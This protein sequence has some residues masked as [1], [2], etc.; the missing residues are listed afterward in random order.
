MQNTKCVHRSS[1]NS[2]PLAQKKEAKHSAFCGSAGARHWLRSMLRAFGILTDILFAQQNE[3]GS[4][5]WFDCCQRH[6]LPLLLHITDTCHKYVTEEMS[7]SLRVAGGS[8]ERRGDEDGIYSITI[9]LVLSPHTSRAHQSSNCR[10]S[11]IFSTFHDFIH[12]KLNATDDDNSVT[13]KRVMKIFTLLSAISSFTDT[14]RG[15]WSAG[16]YART[17][18]KW[19]LNLINFQ[20]KLVVVWNMNF[21]WATLCHRFF[22]LVQLMAT[23]HFRKFSILSLTTCARLRINEKPI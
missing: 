21:L 11:T 10:S 1:T 9:W 7:R 5:D 20:H 15:E 14:V 17:A 3:V 16:T 2:N 13:C 22:I 19:E 6:C 8:C 23:K 4:V 18:A 12:A